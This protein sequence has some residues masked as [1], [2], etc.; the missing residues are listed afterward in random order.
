MAIYVTGDIHGAKDIA[1]LQ[2]TAFTEGRFLTKNDFL[3]ILGDFGLVWHPA[4]G[5][6]LPHRNTLRQDSIQTRALGEEEYWLSFLSAQPW[7]TLF[8]DG[9]HENFD[10]LHAYPVCDFFGGRA[11]RIH[12]TVWY[13]RRGEVFQIDNKTCF[14]MGGASSIDRQ[15][16]TPG[17]DWWSQEVP[18]PEDFAKA[19]HNLS[20]HGNAVDLVF[21][22]TCPESVK[23][24]LPL[25]DMGKA[26]KKKDIHDHTEGMLEGIAA[27]DLQ[28]KH[29]YFAHFHIDALVNER[30]T[31]VFHKILRV[32]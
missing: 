28:F 23:R 27:G 15:W 12:D 19:R 30:F 32:A 31:S 2:K 25:S 6:H 24:R 29:W 1:K 16:R 7:T 14:V 5:A 9:N 18:S 11:S 3:V 10:R 22:H 8:I 13:L 26:S 20:C 4:H 17:L 21:T